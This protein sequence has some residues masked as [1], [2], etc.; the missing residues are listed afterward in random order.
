VHNEDKNSVD[1]KQ[2]IFTLSSLINYIDEE[3]NAWNFKRE[4][5][6]EKR[7]VFF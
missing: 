1:S 2:H 3:T 7:T 5:D 6:R 4:R